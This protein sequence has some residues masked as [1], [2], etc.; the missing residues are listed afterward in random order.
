[1]ESD[2][3]LFPVVLVNFLYRPTADVPAPT[4]ACLIATPSFPERWQQCVRGWGRRT[5]LA[6]GASAPADEALLP[7][8]CGG[9]GAGNLC[10]ES[11]LADV[12]AWLSPRVAARPTTAASAA[13]TWRGYV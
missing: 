5:V 11:A 8:F 9:D 1:M 7:A 10:R 3:L 4:L 13:C 2:P 6:A 12:W